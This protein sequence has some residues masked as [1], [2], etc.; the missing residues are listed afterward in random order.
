MT[1]TIYGATY[2]KPNIKGVFKNSADT[3]LF[4]IW[5]GFVGVG[6]NVFYWRVFGDV[7]EAF[8][9][10]DVSTLRFIGNSFGDLIWKGLGLLS[11]Y[12]HFYAQYLRVI[13]EDERDEWSVLLVPVYPDKSGVFYKLYKITKNNVTQPLRH[14][15]VSFINFVKGVR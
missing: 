7:M 11:V 13:P 6:L 3:L 12:C 10:V 14:I 5:A 4:A 1:L 9:L 15:A 2:F 8:D